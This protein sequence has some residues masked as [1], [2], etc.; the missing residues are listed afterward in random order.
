MS[1]T[2]LI[3]AGLPNRLWNKASDFAAYTKNRLLHKALGWKTIIEM[4]L[5]KDPV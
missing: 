5:T 1:K 4:I 2:D 3:A